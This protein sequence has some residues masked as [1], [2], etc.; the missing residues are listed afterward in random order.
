MSSKWTCGH[1]LTHLA[2][3]REGCALPTVSSQMPVP[4]WAVVS[5]P[6]PPPSG[7]RLDAGLALDDGRG[8]RCEVL[9]LCATLVG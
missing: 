8:A 9:V 4:L 7:C 3:A 6:L 1:L 2:A 5:L